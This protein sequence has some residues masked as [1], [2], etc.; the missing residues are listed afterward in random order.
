NVRPNAYKNLTDATY[1]KWSRAHFPADR[2]N[3]LT[4]NSAESV[5]SLSRKARKLP[6]T[7]LMEFFRELLQRWY[8]ERK[9][10][11]DVG[12]NELTPWV[13]AKVEHEI[14]KS[15]GLS[16]LGINV[17]EYQVMAVSRFVE[18]K[19]VGVLAKSWF[20]RSTYKGTYEESIYPVGDVQGWNTQCDVTHVYPPN[21]G[22]RGVGRPKKDRIPSKGEIP[23]RAYCKR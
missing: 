19:D 5:N 4:S 16:V 13:A 22:I 12:E 11:G 20:E 8:F 18:V 10:D 21:T 15:H 2:Y 23:R 14:R 1:A 3:Y 17:S 9:S 7:M 6:V